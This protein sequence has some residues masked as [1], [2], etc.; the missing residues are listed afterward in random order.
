MNTQQS[1]KT[2]DE[3]KRL[4]AKI[5]SLF[6]SMFGE[7]PIEGLAKA[8][9]SKPEDFGL[10]GEVYYPTAYLYTKVHIDWILEALRLR[11]ELLELQEAA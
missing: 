2:D 8:Y 5:L 9:S 10:S 6:E 1:T 4:E 3:R 7:D 11:K